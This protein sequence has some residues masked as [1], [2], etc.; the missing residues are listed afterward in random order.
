MVAQ[1]RRNAYR[2]LPVGRLV[3]ACCAAAPGVAGDLVVVPD[4]DH[5]VPGVQRL[6]VGFGAVL[7]VP[8]AVV[9]EGEQLVGRHMGARRLGDVLVP[10]VTELDHEAALALGQGP[11]TGSTSEGR[12]GGKWL[13]CKL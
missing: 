12:R 4:G 6:E 11:C 13:C 5:R 9:V 10:V 7:L 2:P 1:G 8:G 3:L